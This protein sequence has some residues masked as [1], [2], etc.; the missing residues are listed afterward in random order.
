MRDRY[1]V[2]ISKGGTKGRYTAIEKN[3]QNKKVFIKFQKNAYVITDITKEL[4]ADFIKYKNKKYGKL[5]IIQLQIIYLLF[6][7][8]RL[9]IIDGYVLPIYFL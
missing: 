5:Q 3:I 8:M 1:T 9:K 6:V 4:A 2:L 7:M